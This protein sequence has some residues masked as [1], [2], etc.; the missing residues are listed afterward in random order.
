MS[1][2][3][4]VGPKHDPLPVGQ[5]KVIAIHPYPVYDYDSAHFWDA[6][7]PRKRAAIAPGP[8][9]PVGVVWISLSKNHYGIHG[10]PN[11]GLIGRGQ[12]HGCIR[13]TNWDASELSGVIQ[14]DLNVVL[15]SE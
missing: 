10:T 9:N 2:P 1:Y 7:G 6:S 11:P 3:V 14:P 5:W 13:M 8:K 12:S 4:S 15:K